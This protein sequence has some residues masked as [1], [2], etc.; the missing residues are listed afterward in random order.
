MGSWYLGKH[1][2]NMDSIDYMELVDQLE[3]NNHLHLIEKEEL[4]VLTN[5]YLDVNKIPIMYKNGKNYYEIHNLAN[6][7][8]HNK[9]KL[10]KLNILTRDPNINSLAR[11][12]F[13]RDVSPLL[14]KDELLVGLPKTYFIIVEFDELK[15]EGILYAERLKEANVDVKVAFYEKAFHGIVNHIHSIVGYKIAVQIQNDLID[16]LKENL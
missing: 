1:E 3:Q 5:S 8:M 15:D 11:L 14:A 9:E 6:K 2:F 7:S 12:L 16:F 4:F 10:N 13:S